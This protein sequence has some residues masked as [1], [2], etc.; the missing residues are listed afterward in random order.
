M[1]SAR[2]FSTALPD[3]VVMDMPAL[4]PTMETG[5]IAS[6][7][8]K[9]GDEVA[10]GDILAEIETDKSGIIGMAEM[11]N[12]CEGHTHASRTHTAYCTRVNDA[13]CN[14]LLT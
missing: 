13:V 9:E 8:K 6:W 12:W 2:M 1:S 14:V 5:N 11:H 7:N 10:A 3:H 4:S